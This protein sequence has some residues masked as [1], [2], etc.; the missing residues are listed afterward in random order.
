MLKIRKE[1]YVKNGNSLR[2]TQEPDNIKVDSNENEKLA[3]DQNFSFG[4]SK[5]LKDDLDVDDNDVGMLLMR[6][7]NTQNSFMVLTII[8][9]YLNY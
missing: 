4:H 7:V 2:V 5:G 8:C 9:V 3:S 6:F 1:E